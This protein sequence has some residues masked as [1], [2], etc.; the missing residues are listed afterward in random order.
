MTLRSVRTF[1]LLAVTASAAAIALAL[2]AGSAG[3]VQKGGG[4]GET[5]CKVVSVGQWY[6]TIDGKGYYCDSSNPTGTQGCI[7]E[8]KINIHRYPV[9]TKG[10]TL[11]TQ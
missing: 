1:A 9:G 6:C 11:K 5:T 4:L 8:R 2:T 10:G 3:A 7:P